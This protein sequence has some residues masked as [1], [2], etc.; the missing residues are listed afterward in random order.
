MKEKIKKIGYLL[1]GI[2]TIALIVLLLLKI[3]I[4]IIKL[5]I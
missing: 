4:E 3:I 2:S 5:L 1:I